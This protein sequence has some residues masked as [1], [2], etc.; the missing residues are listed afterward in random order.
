MK[1]APGFECATQD[2]LAGEAYLWAD[3]VGLSETNF[4][5]KYV[6][7]FKI[8]NVGSIESWKSFFEGEVKMW[9]DEG[10]LHRLHYFEIYWLK[11]PHEDPIVVSRGEDGKYIVWDGA[12]RLGIQATYGRLTIP[13]IVGV[14]K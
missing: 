7:D 2:E 3:N 14:P 13:A 10:L 4:E 12:H 11:N 1:S 6:P 9:K 5:W 8:D